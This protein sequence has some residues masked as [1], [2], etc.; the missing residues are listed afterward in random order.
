MASQN[1]DER[2][3]ELARARFHQVELLFQATS[4]MTPTERDDYLQREDVSEE[5]RREVVALWACDAIHDDAFDDARLA[6]SRATKS[7]FSAVDSMPPSLSSGT[8]LGD[9]RLKEEIGRGGMAVVYRARQ[10]SLDRIVALKVL[11][12]PLTT[13]AA[14][15]RFQREATAGARLH[16]DS[17]VSVYHYGDQHNLLFF[18]MEL[19]EG[20]TLAAW[21]TQRRSENDGERS[22][23]SACDRHSQVCR[24]VAEV[25]DGLA[26]AHANGVIHRDIK[27]SNVIVTPAGH[28]KILDFGVAKLSC[29]AGLTTT[30]TLVGTP[31]YMSPEQLSPTEQEVDHRTDIYSLGATMYELLTL[32]PPYPADD[33]AQLISQIL[34]AEPPLPRRWNHRIPRPLETICLKAM[35]KEPHERYQDAEEF[36]EDLRNW[37]DGRPIAAIRRGPITHF[38]RTAVARRNRTLAVMS[39]LLLVCAATI[40][41]VLLWPKPESPVAP[42]P[43]TIKDPRQITYVDSDDYALDSSLS[44]DGCWGA[45]ISDSGSETGNTDVFIHRL[46]DPSLAGGQVES[47]GDP[48]QVTFT[49]SNEIEP[50]LSPNGEW[51][52]YGTTGAEGGV[53]LMHL[54]E[55]G[56]PGEVVQIGGA[57]GRTPR[58]SPNGKHIAW[59]VGPMSRQLGILGDS[60]WIATIDDPSG[61]FGPPQPFCQDFAMV[62]FPVWS[63]DSTHLLFKGVRPSLSDEIDPVRIDTG[64]ADWWVAP[65]DGSQP[66][67]PLGVMQRMHDAGIAWSSLCA[68]SCWTPR[69]HCVIFTGFSHSGAKLWALPLSPKTLEATGNPYLLS[70]AGSS[71]EY[72]AGNDFGRG[73]FERCCYTSGK[74]DYGIWKLPI[75]ADQAVKT[76]EI[77]C[78]NENPSMDMTPSVSSD[79]RRIVF[80]SLRGGPFDIWLKEAETADVR[81]ITQ[82]PSEKGYSV[83]S[84]D[85][86][87]VAY[88]DMGH[89][90]VYDPALPRPESMLIVIDLNREESPSRVVAKSVGIPHHWYPSSLP[91][92]ILTTAQGRLNLVDADSPASQNRAVPLLRRDGW[93]IEG[94]KFSPDGQ[95][96]AFSASRIGDLQRG[97]IFV[98]PYE[99]GMEVMSEEWIP[100]L[101]ES[102]RSD[103]GHLPDWSPNGE[104]LYFL[105]DRTGNRCLRYQRLDATTKHPVDASE[106]LYSFDEYR[107][108]PQFQHWGLLRLSVARD[109]IVLSLANSTANVYVGRLEEH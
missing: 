56:N 88:V 76:G 84:Q 62:S 45:F 99:L 96:I 16:H 78:V 75:N 33:S 1:A 67:R 50:H 41:W 68:P 61:E 2:E 74:F 86:S 79:G 85:G 108:S 3:Q 5:L 12:F 13:E 89:R 28:V 55:N 101:D 94:G 19:V 35:A 46:S 4:R 34:E 42:R 14:R 43:T 30:G 21:L 29:E 6:A 11:S 59:W 26:H 53:Y 69:S 23:R 82:G 52:V 66:A 39:A 48:K 9:F 44:G 77:E 47:L 51:L 49:A 36:A 27:P 100:I 105:S 81:R 106:E 72:F 32:C 80:E 107:L 93:W 95:W 104:I 17:I 54:D 60:L 83:V 71:N 31:R 8:L 90:T 15:Q 92:Y 91:Q 97:Q 73:E 24:W 109:K 57:G 25:A 20:Q 37:L 38:V 7:A 87:R 102:D 63:P 64:A 10:V 103:D 22:S 40:A 58:F 98:A 18:A 65:I 70:G